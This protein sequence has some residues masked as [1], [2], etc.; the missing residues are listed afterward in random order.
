MSAAVDLAT[1][2]RVGEALY[3]PRWQMP[4]ARALGPLRPSGGTGG[5]DISLMQRWVAG[6]RPLPQWI[7]NTVLVAVLRQARR[8]HLEAAARLDALVAELGS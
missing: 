5:I 1:L 2:R 4:L 8:E 6:R 7:D 3:G